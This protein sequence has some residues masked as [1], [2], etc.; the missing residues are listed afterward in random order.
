M[1]LA[2]DNAKRVCESVAA[3]MNFGKDSFPLIVPVIKEL[4]T[5]HLHRV[6]IPVEKWISEGLL[7]ANYLTL[8]P[9]RQ[10]PG[11]S[12]PKALIE[13]EFNTAPRAKL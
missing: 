9:E 10:L 7:P 5:G 13:T 4:S 8:H 2:I 3:K 12:L 6:P 1:L 11:T